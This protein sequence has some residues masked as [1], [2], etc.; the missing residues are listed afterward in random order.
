MYMEIPLLFS[1]DGRDNGGQ[2]DVQAGLAAD[3]EVP[4]DPLHAPSEIS[5][6]KTRPV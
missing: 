5:S 3:K 6:I 4:N 1:K 2:A